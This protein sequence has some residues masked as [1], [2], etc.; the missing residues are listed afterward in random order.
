[1]I[2]L[3]PFLMMMALLPAMLGV[4]APSSGKSPAAQ[5]CEPQTAA[6]DVRVPGRPFSAAEVA[7]GIAAFAAIDSDRP[8]RDSGI[9]V[10]L[11]RNGRL[12]YS[13]LVPISPQPAGMALTHDGRLLVVADDAFIVFVDVTRAIA[14]RSAVLGYMKAADGDIE[15]ADPAAVY[16][17]ISPDDRFAF[18][19]EESNESITVVD[20]ARARSSNYSRRS[21]V[22]EIPVGI[23]PIVTIFS[24]DGRTMFATSEGAPKSVGWLPACKPEGS[25]PNTPLERQPGAIFAI[26]VAKAERDPARAVQGKVPGECSPV[27]M[28]LSSDGT[29]AWVTNRGSDSV[30]LFDTA[31]I[32]ASNPAAKLVSIP[33]GSNPVALA[34]TRDDRYVLAGITNRFGPGG[35]N[36]GHLAVIDAHKRSLVGTIPTG[37]FPRQFS[38][39]VGT[40]LF[41][42]NNR[43]DSITVLD[44][45]KIA[46]LVRPESPH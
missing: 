28:D 38:R 30:S 46:T 42:A 18:I 15:D 33:V 22:G 10:M 20:L 11:C 21:V 5:R 6:Y 39:G 29:F 32:V 8:D 44:E 16:A 34:V 7:S 4:V 26:D 43:S 41:L 24:P 13:H 14:G 1:M 36:A 19:S 27:R 9:A 2:V 40:T 31:Q 3:R 23:A 17:S 37:E 45:S 12:S 25:P 35:T